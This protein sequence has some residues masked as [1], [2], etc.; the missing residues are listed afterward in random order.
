[1]RRRIPSA[2]LL[3][4]LAATS[5]AAVSPAQPRDGDP[6]AAVGPRV[7]DVLAELVPE[8]GT[9]QVDILDLVETARRRAYEQTPGVVP[10]LGEE[11][12]AP[13]LT[14]A[15]PASGSAARIEWATAAPDLDGDGR[16]DLFLLLADDPT[17]LS[18]V[19][20]YDGA[21]LWRIARDA[22]AP[23]PYGVEDV[24]GDGIGDLLLVWAD[25]FEGEDSYEL[26]GDRERYESQASWVTYTELRSGADGTLLSATETPGS[27][28]Y[29]SERETRTTADPLDRDRDAYRYESDVVDAFR[30]LLPSA[31]HDGDGRTDLVSLTVSSS[32]ADAYSSESSLLTGRDEA[33]YRSAGSSDARVVDA[34]GATLWQLPDHESGREGF[35][36]PGGD[37]DG[38]GGGDLLWTGYGNQRSTSTC[39]RTVVLNDCQETVSAEPWGMASVH[40][41][42]T[43]E[44]VW[45]ADTD[46]GL[47]QTGS[48]LQPVLA[49]L[50]GDGADDLLGY[51]RALSGRD[52][53]EL[54]ARE[55][56]WYGLLPISD[57]DGSPV[58]LSAQYGY[59]S[60]TCAPTAEG[61]IERLTLHR[62]DGRTGAD[63][64]SSE[65]TAGACDEYG[66][67]GFHVSGDVD[68]DGVLD[69]VVFAYEE[70]QPGYYEAS[71]FELESG[72]TGDVLATFASF[73]DVTADLDGDGGADLLMRTWEQ[74][75]S[76]TVAMGD[77][78]RTELWRLADTE[79]SGTYPRIVGDLDG[80]GGRDVAL[81]DYEY[82]PDGGYAQRI[83]FGRGADLS[84][85]WS[86]ATR[87][88][89]SEWIPAS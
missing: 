44:L 65:R 29:L 79:Q 54:W 6:S 27:A 67:L 85:I 66:F 36:V 89:S 77:L 39:D 48:Y 88:V 72:A 37:L 59:G 55:D 2:L 34:S 30:W 28:R 84:V 46:G 63:L 56:L 35:L 43:F 9:G 64:A 7:A 26:D 52:A 51:N 62:V 21:P 12:G 81:H 20:G 49:D 22:W 86:G 60:D 18:A 1:M 38:D 82:L 8:P 41:G 33:E 3:T 14:T 45:T 17:S 24:T 15:E 13:M 11:E 87:R 80:D 68:A 70:T 25:G 47:A 10:L 61:R 32:Y 78:G 73:P 74:G 53:D 23:D 42:T 40:N 19:R 75:R 50:D 58:L 57:R 4:S 83:R 71:S 31:D 16:D 5:I 76:T 69:V